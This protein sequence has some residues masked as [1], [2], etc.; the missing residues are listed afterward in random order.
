LAYL[1]EVVLWVKEHFRKPIPLF[2]KVLMVPI[3]KFIQRLGQFPCTGQVESTNID[4]FAT[5]FFPIINNGVLRPVLPRVGGLEESVVPEQ[6]FGS[7]TG[8]CDGIAFGNE[9][10]GV[11]GEWEGAGL[12]GVSE[13]VLELRVDQCG[14]EGLAHGAYSHYINPPHQE[15]IGLA[16]PESVSIY[17]RHSR[18]VGV[19][20][21]DD[22]GCRFSS[23]KSA[24]SNV[25]RGAKELDLR[26][27]N[28][29]RTKV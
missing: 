29:L 17:D 14:S 1:V 25:S 9:L 2:A 24:I 18:A 16:C 27:E 20:H 23:S 21:I 28:T 7:E 26:G 12:S 5:T 13:V 4:D 6:G 22:Q 15:E 19:S 3:R 10:M 11:K 8:F